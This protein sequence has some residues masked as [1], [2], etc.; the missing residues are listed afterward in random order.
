MPDK[1][2][3]WVKIHNN[4]G[5]PMIGIS[6]VHKYSNVYKEEKQWDKLENGETTSEALG[7]DYNTGFLTT[8]RD[9]WF[10]MWFHPDMKYIWHSSP[11]NMRGFFDFADNIVPDAIA[12][13]AGA[14]AGLG[15][16]FTGPGAVVAAA[17]AAAAAKLVTSSLFNSEG[18]EGF[19]QHM[20]EEEDEGEIMEIVV[21]LEDVEFKSKS[22]RSTTDVRGQD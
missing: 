10:I 12:G 21:N 1:R 13:A 19:K 4:T 2:R 7:V 6:L 22:G 15:G 17:A 9:W 5:K 14:A 11:I 3:A 8:G 18:T 16:A 20:L